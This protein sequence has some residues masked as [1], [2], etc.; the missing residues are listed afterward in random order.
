MLGATVGLLVIFCQQS[1]AQL[2]RMGLAFTKEAVPYS[3]A[4]PIVGPVHPGGALTFGY[5][6]KATDDWSHWLYVDLGGYHHAQ[7][8]TGA[9]VQGKYQWERTLPHGFTWGVGAGVGYLHAF[10]PNGRF[11]L[12]DGELVQA[13][14]VGRSAATAQVGTSLAWSPKALPDWQV[15]A[16]LQGWV[17]GPFAPDYGVPVFPHTFLQLGITKTI[18]EYVN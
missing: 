10:F 1:Y 7:F 6:R 11:Q 9:Y 18:N 5:Q 4:S 16:Q 12:Q 8:Q 13:P 3:L 17:E 2:Y 15:V 14:P